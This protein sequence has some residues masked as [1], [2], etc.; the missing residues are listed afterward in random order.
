MNAHPAPTALA[1]LALLAALACAGPAAVPTVE[2]GR[3]VE[4]AVLDNFQRG[5]TTRGEAL[6]LL[7]EPSTTSSNPED[8]SITCSWDYFH[9]DGR[10]STATMTILKFGPDDTLQIKMVS[11]SSQLRP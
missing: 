10:G 7:G 6:A 3:L 11:R 5:V 2:R 4:K 9:S 8:G 1:G